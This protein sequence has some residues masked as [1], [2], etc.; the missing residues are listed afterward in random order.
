MICPNNRYTAAERE[1]AQAAFDHIAE[2]R[3]VFD[4]LKLILIVYASYGVSPN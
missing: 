1:E 4:L 2:D 3:A